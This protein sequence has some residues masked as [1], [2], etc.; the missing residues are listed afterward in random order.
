MKCPTCNSSNNI[1]HDFVTNPETNE[2]YRRR[3][4]KNCGRVFFTVEFEVEV[5]EKLQEEWL[6]S[7]ES[8]R[9]NVDAAVEMEGEK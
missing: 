3:D 2:V 9:E 1:T 5:T 4:C 8:M 7:L 6:K